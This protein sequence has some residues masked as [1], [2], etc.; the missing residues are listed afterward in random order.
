MPSPTELS[1][2]FRADQISLARDTVREMVEVAGALSFTAVDASA[3]GW[4]TAVE[5]IV[6]KRYEESL[7]RGS[8]LY[9]DYQ[10]ASG[11]P[12]SPAIVTPMLDRDALR[13]SLLVLGP[14]AAKKQMSLGMSIPNV[15]RSVFTNTAATAAK[16]VLNGARDTIQATAVSDVRCTGYMRVTS[17]KPCAFCA[18]IAG[19]T[20]RSVESASQSSGFRTRATNPQPP[21]SRYH[22][23][24][25][26][27]VVPIFT[28]QSWPDGYKAKA[29]DY[30]SLWTETA[31]AGGSAKEKQDRFFEA[32]N[33][34]YKTS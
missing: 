7:A 9:R 1:A 30:S 28:A 22:A 6:G 21:K 12:G 8:E 13:G 23:S 27:T 32:F 19:N 14:Y 25:R 11:L 4:M 3:T 10:R 2:R 5:S 33:A 16:M 24:C 20:Y 31:K 17:G 15:A 29:S 26:C 18:M 34:Q